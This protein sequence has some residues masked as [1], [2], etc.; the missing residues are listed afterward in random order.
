MSTLAPTRTGLPSGTWTV[1]PVHSSVGFSARHMVVST[2]RGG[3]GDFAAT[4]V[5]GEDGIGRLEGTIEAASID[6][7][8]PS[9]T[10]HLHSPEFLDTEA[11]PQ[12][13]F[14]SHGVSLDGEIVRAPG[15]IT[16]KGITKPVVATGTLTG[17]TEDPWGTTR[18]GV[19]LTTTV[20]R[21]EIGMSWNTA[22][23][24]GGLALGNEVTLTLGLEFVLDRS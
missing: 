22:L 3:F 15:E 21:R 14:A 2:F 7:R 24:S 20:D 8:D 10:G 12:L 16:V 9:L 5:V 13:R 6:T 4:L 18:L 19:E 11:H 23:P 1:D 17:P